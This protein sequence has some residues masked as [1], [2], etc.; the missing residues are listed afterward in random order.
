MLVFGSELKA[1]LEHPL[2]DPELNEDALRQALRFRAI[3]TSEGLSRGV[4]QLEPGGYLEFTRT[5]LRTGR[6]LRVA[7]EVRR[8]R[9]DNLNVGDQELI[10]R[11]REIFMDSVRQRLVADVPVGA[12]LSGGLDSSLI[13][14]AMRAVREPGAQ[15]ETAS[16]WASPATHT[17]SFHYAQTVADAF[18]TLHRPITVGPGGV[19]VS[20]SGRSFGL[21]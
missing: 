5:G 3:Y 10:R 13:V 21:P 7:D 20:S 8:S 4:R 1:L 16:P 12:F 17:V 6:F 19:K 2:L 15:I 18:H 9:R 14:A 11:G